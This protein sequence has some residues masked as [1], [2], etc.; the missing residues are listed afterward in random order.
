FFY[1]PVFA[2]VGAAP[3]G[4]APQLLKVLYSRPKHRY[5][6]RTHPS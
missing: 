2:S 3:I 1:G 4:T 5:T 6:L